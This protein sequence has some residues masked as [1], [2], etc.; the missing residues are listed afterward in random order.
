MLSELFDEKH[1]RE[2]YDLALAKQN[3]AIGEERG[4]KRGKAIGEAIG[5]ERGKAI[6]EAKGIIKALVALVKKGI[7]TVPQAAEEAEMSVEEFE[8]E[9]GLKTI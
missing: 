2:R 8:A 4:E 5:E 9:S 7:L 6:G 1:L 3:Q